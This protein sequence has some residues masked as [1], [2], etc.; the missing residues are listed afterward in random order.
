MAGL[1]VGLTALALPDVLG[2]GTS[3]LR[4]ATIEGAFGLGEVTVL[5][6][7]KIVLTALCIGAGFSGARSAPRF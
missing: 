1:A 7:A 5:I 4:F 2:I 6:V 3:T